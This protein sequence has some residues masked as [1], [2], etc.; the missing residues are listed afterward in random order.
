MTIK[1]RGNRGIPTRYR[2][3]RFR[4]RLEARYAAFFDLID[5]RWTYEPFDGD[6][7]IPDF[8]IQGRSPFL[9]EVGP[10]LSD[11]DYD[12]KAQKVRQAFPPVNVY[13]ERIAHEDCSHG[14]DYVIQTAPER[15]TL[16]LGAAALYQPRE[17]VP[18]EAA[19]FLTTDG[20]ADW[21]A[22]AIWGLCPT[23]NGICVT[24]AWGTYTHFPCGHY[25]GGDTAWRQ[26]LGWHLNDRWQRAAN[27]TQWLAKRSA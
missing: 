25:T 24:H 11:D 8:L 26:D 18:G 22:A 19:G 15:T 1:E 27:L 6:G 12:A 17:E 5:W 14:D 2:E 3:T 4:S 13:C 16:V 21:W 10:C 20:T 23:C 9:V 7:W